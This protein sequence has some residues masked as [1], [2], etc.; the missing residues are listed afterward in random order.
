MLIKTVDLKKEYTR[1]FIFYTITASFLLS[2]YC[3]SLCWKRWKNYEGETLR[4]GTIAKAICGTASLV[5]VVGIVRIVGVVGV[6]LLML[7]LEGMLYNSSLTT[8]HLPRQ[9]SLGSTLCAL[10]L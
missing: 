1:K 2:S 9:A 8:H 7:S 5:E 4:C 10:L 3:K 6:V